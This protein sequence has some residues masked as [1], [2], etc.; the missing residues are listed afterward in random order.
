[1]IKPIIATLEKQLVIKKLGKLATLDIQ[2]LQSSLRQIIA[3]T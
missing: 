3:V 2:G 1:V